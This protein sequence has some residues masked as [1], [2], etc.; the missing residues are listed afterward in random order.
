MECAASKELVSA[1]PQKVFWLSLV[2]EQRFS[3]PNDTESFDSFRENSRLTGLCG[4]LT[5][6][7]ESDLCTFLL[8]PSNMCRTESSLNQYGQVMHGNHL[9]SKKS[10]AAHRPPLSP[11]LIVVVYLFSPRIILPLLDLRCATFCKLS[12]RSLSMVQIY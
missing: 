1:I 12:F 5:P 8:S 3:S 11:A 6:R 10:R 7:R 2:I 4:F 9:H